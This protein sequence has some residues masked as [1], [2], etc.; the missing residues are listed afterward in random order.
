MRDG[1]VASRLP[2]KQKAAGAI[3]APATILPGCITTWFEKPPG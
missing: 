2:H 1:E 3:P